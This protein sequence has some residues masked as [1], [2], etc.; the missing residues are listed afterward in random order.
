[1]EAEDIPAPKYQG[2]SWVF[3]CPEC[4]FGDKWTSRD[5]VERGTPVC[6]H[7]DEDMRIRESATVQFD[8]PKCGYIG[9]WEEKELFGKGDP[10]CPRCNTPMLFSGQ[11]P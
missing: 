11:V 10:P 2:E 3:E 9:Y 6:P 7:C 4:G 1:M 8:C 5:L